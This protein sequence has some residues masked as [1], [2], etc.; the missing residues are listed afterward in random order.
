M[1]LITLAK[2]KLNLPNHPD[3]DPTP[4]CCIFFTGPCFTFPPNVTETVPDLHKP[5]YQTT[6]SENIACLVKITITMFFEILHAVFTL[7]R[8]V[9]LD[10]Y[11]ISLCRFNRINTDKTKW[12]FWQKIVKYCFNFAQN[13]NRNM[14]QDDDDDV[15]QLQLH[16]QTLNGKINILLY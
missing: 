6:S 7:V 5:L 4:K 1:L 15:T 8:G 2:L 10:D 3:S 12:F 13:W 11:N 16:T 14:D 9:F